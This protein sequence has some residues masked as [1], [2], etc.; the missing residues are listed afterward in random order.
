MI[1]IK[2]NLDKLEDLSHEFLL[3]ELGSI[4][5]Q[6]NQLDKTVNK[7]VVEECVVLS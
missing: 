3:I 4:E 5:K 1:L 7:L 6:H 2:L